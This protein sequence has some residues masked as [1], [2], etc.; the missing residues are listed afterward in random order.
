M[1]ASFSNLNALL[2][3]FQYNGSSGLCAATYFNTV[4][5]QCDF[6][7]AAAG[8]IWNSPLAPSEAHR[9]NPA[10]ETFL[11]RAIDAPAEV[12]EPASLALFALG[13]AGAAATRRMFSN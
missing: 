13:L 11:V 9:T 12:P 4:Y 7:D 10:S 6:S 2:A 3:A 1:N 8:Y 5:D